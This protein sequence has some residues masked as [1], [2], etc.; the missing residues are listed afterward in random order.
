MIKLACRVE[1][2]HNSLMNCDLFFIVAALLVA[3][4]AGLLTGIFGAGGGFILTPALIIILHIE[5]AIAVGTSLSMIVCASSLCMIRRRGSGTMDWKMAGLLCVGAC[6]GVFLGQRLMARLQH[7][8]QL[9]ISGN[10][11]PATEYTLL[12]LFFVLLAF[13]AWYLWFDYYKNRGKPP[14]TRIGLLQQLR[15]P[16]M[17]NFI[18]LETPGLSGSALLA[19]GVLVGTLTGLLGIGGG[20]VWLPALI[21]LVGQRTVQATGTSLIMIWLSS[22]FGAGLYLAAGQ[23]NLKLWL[24]LILGGLVGA[25]IGT[26]IG[27]KIS[28]S[29]LRL[30]FIYVVILANLMVVIKLVAM[31]FG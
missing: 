4:G 24:L 31:T 1:V 16:P 23:V 9:N 12:W 13:I 5:P 15:L 17:M 7:L 28:G 14:A 25:W 30:A 22:L 6:A 11:I 21:Y 29:R 20:V 3:G 26:P 10:L 8:P 18:S 2:R 19:L 27:L